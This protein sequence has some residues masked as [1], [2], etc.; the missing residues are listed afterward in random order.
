MDGRRA[1][2]RQTLRGSADV[3][4]DIDDEI[5]FH[6][7]MRERDFIEAG[8]TPEQA[9]AAATARLGDL[10]EVRR[11][12]T[13]HDR[14]QMRRI[15]I[16]EAAMELAQDVRYGL[17]KLAQQP[18][19]TLALVSVLALGTGA[20][21][22]VFSAVDAVLLRRLPF[23][24]P[25]RLVLVDLGVPF[26]PGAGGPRYP[27]GAPD[28]TDARALTD[29]FTGVAAY[30]AGAL[31]L[32][33]DAS[34]RRVRVGAVTADLF[35]LLGTFPVMGREFA[36]SDGTPGTPP[37][38]IVSEGLW[39]S[40]FGADPSAVGAEIVLN[41]TPR[42]IIGVMPRG[43]HFPE[44]SEL[45][46]PLPVPYTRAS[47]EPFRQYMPSHTVARLRNGIDV[48]EARA[49]ALALFAPYA[50]PER[51][52]AAD[53][54]ELIRPFRE[55]TVGERRT[56]LLVLLGATALVLVVA[57]ANVA[58][59]LL[60]RATVRRRE[61]ALRAVL[62]ASPRRV[63]R[64]LATESLLLAMIGAA[65]G[66]GLAL[67]GIRALGALVPPELAGLATL[68]VDARVLAFA[69]CVAIATAVFFGLWPALDGRRANVGDALR[70]GSP[71][72]GAEASAVRLREVFVVG[73]LALALMLLVGSTLMLR[74]LHVLLTTESGID[75]EGVVSLELTLARAEFPVPETRQRFYENVLERLAADPRI[76]SAAAINELP[77]RGVGAVQ[78]LMYPQGR[79][80][81]DPDKTPAQYLQV[82]PEYFR[83]MGIRVLAGRA[84]LPG[85]PEGLP[86]EVV[87][88]ESLAELYWP[89]KAPLG[90]IL[91]WPGGTFEVVG[92]V[93]DVRP[94]TLESDFTPQA[95]APMRVAPDL[96]LVARGHAD[97]SELAAILVEAVHDVAP[98]QAVYNVRTMEQ[99]ISGAIRA[100][101]T[102]T[103]LITT[104]GALALVLA[105]VGVYGVMAFNVARR[106][107]EIG[108]RIALGAR[109]RRVLASILREGLVLTA[110][111]GAIGLAG[112]WTLASVLEGLLFGITSRDPVTFLVAPLILLTVA[113]AAVLLPAWRATRVNP[114]EAIRME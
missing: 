8:L 78:L 91:D 41:G 17:R 64:Q 90:E 104:F 16:G 111:G 99:V 63:F 65:A 39:R 96:A 80:P 32:S 85:R 43:F 73:E 30:A 28:I 4:R 100:R 25:D 53:A 13:R 88:S 57:C 103:L 77:L 19:F 49:R 42:E 86:E 108:I 7:Q 22:A 110:V 82:T 14:R 76:E 97:P 1:R 11:W 102:N 113:V 71:G 34:P 84:P 59:L 105:A 54:A 98:R 50:S 93:E 69:L 66:T 9:R 23:A 24:D 51:P 52:A 35:S 38:V 27:K 106:T 36:P 101:R 5:S 6:V 109:A 68:R 46:V 67:V 15:E 29:V 12:L 2:W 48:A 60:S 94:T 18:L 3:E 89:G 79:P 107:R 44:E 95:Y 40:H 92:V 74:S 45:W 62:G 33:D 26:D 87:I 47:M 56:A 21:T 31:N 75:P 83:V 112:A 61:V 37:V 70:A 72:A 81:E 114:V 58:N 20:T 55:A 10:E